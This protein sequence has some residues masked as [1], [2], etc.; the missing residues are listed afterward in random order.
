MNLND[1]KTSEIFPAV[2]AGP[3]QRIPQRFC[4]VVVGHLH[5]PR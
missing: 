3:L 1:A 2:S 4:G 5:Q